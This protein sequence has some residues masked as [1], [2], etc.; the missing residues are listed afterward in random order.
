MPIAAHFDEKPA[1]KA[2][3]ARR[4]LRLETEGALPTGEAARVLVHNVSQTG[5]LLECGEAIEPGET[6]AVAL[7]HAGTLEARI[8][9]SSGDLHG[10][11]FDAPV[12]PATL[13]AAE[14]RSAVGGAMAAPAGRPAPVPETGTFGSRLQR[15]RKSRR[16]TLAQVADSLG[17]SKPTVWAWEHDK[18]RPL[19]SR[20]E[21]LATLLGVSG[22][23]IA[24]S[25]DS[26]LRA[27]VVAQA[28]ASIAAA[29]ATD[30][31]R[32]RIMIE[33]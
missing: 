9:W 18:A 2:R 6:I 23:E 30:S 19:D 10:C 17:V 25:Q 13:S 5:M 32:V 11:Q 12:S 4:T 24:S 28:R 29:Y 14:L 3:A 21:A 1:N 20:L 15:L 8:V 22:E 31:A 16:L 7:P 27:N 26:D 33:L